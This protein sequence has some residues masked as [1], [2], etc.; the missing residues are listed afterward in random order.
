[1][2]VR[3]GGMAAMPSK[4]AVILRRLAAAQTGVAVKYF[5]AGEPPEGG[6]VG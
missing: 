2:E 6:V 1:M 3:H 4:V 5:E